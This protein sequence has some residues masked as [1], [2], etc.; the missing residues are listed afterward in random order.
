M[1]ERKS[2]CLDVFID[3]QEVFRQNLIDFLRS[4]HRDFDLNIAQ[5]G[6]WGGSLSLRILTGEASKLLAH[7][8]RNVDGAVHYSYDEHYT[9]D[10]AEKSVFWDSGKHKPFWLNNKEE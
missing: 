4:I 6:N 7:I 8:L 1:V 2:Y 3:G 5:C 10:Q 9:K